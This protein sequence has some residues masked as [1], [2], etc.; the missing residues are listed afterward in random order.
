MRKMILALAVAAAIAGSIAR[1]GAAQLP[2][3]PGLGS[4]P[5]VQNDYS[6]SID[7]QW[8]VR[9]PSGWMKEKWSAVVRATGV[10]CT[11]TSDDM[12]QGQLKHTDLHGPGLFHITLDPG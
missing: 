1:A 11:G 7:F 12:S 3:I 6:G 8:E 5:Q 4:P 10:E 9:G 2:R